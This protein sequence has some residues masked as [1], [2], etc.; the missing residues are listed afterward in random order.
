[1]NYYELSLDNDLKILI[2]ADDTENND[3]YEDVS[4]KDRIIS[5]STTFDSLYSPVFAYIKKVDETL[6]MMT[7]VPDEIELEFSVKLSTEA[8]VIITKAGAEATATIKLTWK[9]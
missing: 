9:K 6:Q 2:E 5:H 3:F 7:D 1:M 4:K 8:G